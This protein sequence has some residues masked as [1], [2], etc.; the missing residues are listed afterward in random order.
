M[1]IPNLDY[2]WFHFKNSN[3]NL[4]FPQDE[5]F[6]LMKRQYLKKVLVGRFKFNEISKKN[7][8]VNI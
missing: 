6:S 7:N 4:F 5:F 3:I 2:F 8:Q 1:Y